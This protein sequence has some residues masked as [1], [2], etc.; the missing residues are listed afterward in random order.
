MEEMT[1]VKATWRM[2]AY[3]GAVHAFTNPGAGTD[4]SQGAAYDADADA[5]SQKA[6]DA[7]FAELFGKK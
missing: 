4:P 7:F 3:G 5:R 1:K 6:Q 2:E